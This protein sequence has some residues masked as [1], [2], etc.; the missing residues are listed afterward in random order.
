MI[1]IADFYQVQTGRHCVDTTHAPV[2]CLEHLADPAWWLFTTA[3]LDQDAGYAAHHVVQKGIG[4]NIKGDKTAATFD[5]KRMYG[6]DRAVCL[7]GHGAKRAKVVF[8]QQVLAS[9]HHFICIQV[10]MLPADMVS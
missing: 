1:G 8:S 2:F 7:A 5:F 4:D 10:S 6:A 3:G 9:L